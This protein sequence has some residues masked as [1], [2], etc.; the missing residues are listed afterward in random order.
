MKT[1][2]LFIVLVLAAFLP[3]CM[4]LPQYS[5][6]PFADQSGAEGQVKVAGIGDIF[7]DRSEGQAVKDEKNPTA[8]PVPYSGFKYELTIVELN[9]ERLGLQ[10]NEYTYQPVFVPMSATYYPGSWMVKQGFNKRFDY[11]VSDKIIRFKGNEFE[12][13]SVENGQIRY[14]RVK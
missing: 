3:S 4:S 11:A 12:I 8:E 5:Y 10:Y 6:V 7:F 9:Q 1:I 13:L 14:R 2:K